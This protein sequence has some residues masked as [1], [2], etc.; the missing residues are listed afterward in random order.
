[1]KSLFIYAKLC[2][3]SAAKCT[4]HSVHFYI[5]LYTYAQRNISGFQN[6]IWGIMQIESVLP[7]SSSATCKIALH[8]W[9]PF[10]QRCRQ[11]ANQLS[12]GL[13]LRII[14]GQH[15]SV[16][17]NWIT[18]CIDLVRVY[19]WQQDSVWRQNIEWQCCFARNFAKCCEYL[20]TLHNISKVHYANCI[21]YW[22]QL[23]KL[24]ET[25]QGYF[26]AYHKQSIKKD[27]SDYPGPWL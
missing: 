26:S 22:L 25:I 1:M 21:A 7:C 2:Y 27:V 8:E 23:F 11:F 6:G 18:I 9:W 17:S 14:L 4:G 15:N 19:Q 24:E 12:A 5:L 10:V 3:M 13:K 20:V 16:V